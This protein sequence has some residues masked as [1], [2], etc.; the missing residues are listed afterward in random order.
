MILPTPTPPTLNE[1]AF[2]GVSSVL[3][4]ARTM[5]LF[6]VAAPSPFSTDRN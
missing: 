3:P 2:A 5:L 6:L 4:T 1:S